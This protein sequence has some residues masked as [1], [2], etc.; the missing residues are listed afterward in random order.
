[1]AQQ[2]DVSSNQAIPPALLLH[3]VSSLSSGVLAVE[4]DG[5]IALINSA[6][7]AHLGL[8]DI[9]PGRGRPLAE[10]PQLAV[11][12]SLAQELLATREPLSRKEIT[13]ASPD[14]DRILGV[15]ASLLPQGGAVFLFSDLTRIR[16][17]ER[18]AELNQQLAQ[19]G[20]LTAGVV[21]ELRNPLSVIGGMAELL[22]R[23]LQDEPRLR[24]NAALIMEEV[25][26]LERLIKDFLVF[27]KPYGI[28]KGICEPGSVV[29]RAHRQV[30]RLARESGVT[31]DLIIGPGLPRIAADAPKLVQAL[32]NLLRNAIEVSPSGARVRFEAG[33]EEHAVVF[34]VADEGP[35]INPELGDAIFNP[36]FSKKAGGTGLGLS[37]VHR[38]VSGHGGTIGYRNA[39]PAGAEFEVR[40]PVS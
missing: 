30:E 35:G 23:R 16:E 3:I 10:V 26:S 13:V 2:P 14:G 5:R 38:I 22:H 17:L 1:M 12:E 31:L 19:I 36:F 18:Q 21:H 34:R 4:N 28:E 32:S 39:K 9:S 33:L 15:N 6:A 8:D 7:C 11:F 29:Q 37:I 24:T 27:S 25:E 20:E 40:L